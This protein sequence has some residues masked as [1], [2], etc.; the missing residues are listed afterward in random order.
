[1]DNSGAENRRDWNQEIFDLYAARAEKGREDW[2]ETQKKRLK[3]TKPGLPPAAYAGLYRSPSFGEIRIQGSGSDMIL[4][5]ALVDF[6]MSH[7]HL[8]TYLVEFKTWE[9]H[10][11]ASFNIDP[12]GSIQ[13]V[14][15]FGETFERVQPE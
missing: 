2:Q 3:H 14:N 5:T 4:K 7:W 6:E 9:M 12:E 1:M 8:D 10:E 15:V 13:S 11:F